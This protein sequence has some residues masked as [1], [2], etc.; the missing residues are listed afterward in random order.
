MQFGSVLIDETS[1][2]TE[3]ECTVPAAPGDRQARPPSGLSPSGLS[4]PLLSHPLLSHPLL[5]H[6]LL[7]QPEVSQD[8]YLGDE[9][10]PQTDVA[11]SQDCTYQ[12]ERA[13][14]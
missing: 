12:G 3:P 13:Y 4:H 5:S 1:P 7:S 6:P 14:H 9:F 10:K 8:G 11:L 2:A